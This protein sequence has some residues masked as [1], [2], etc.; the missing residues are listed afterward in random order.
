V[1]LVAFVSAEQVDTAL[2]DAASSFDRCGKKDDP[3]GGHLGETAALVAVGATRY[4]EP[5]LAGEG[6]VSVDYLEDD[7]LTA[8][9]ACACRTSKASPFIGE[10]RNTPLQQMKLHEPFDGSFDV[11]RF[12]T[13]DRPPSSLCGSLGLSDRRSPVIR[14][15]CEVILECIG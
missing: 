3:G 5:H 12:D 11:V 2:A 15:V 13:A 14:P 10:V 7:Q 4:L 9:C 1:C 6:R 8:R